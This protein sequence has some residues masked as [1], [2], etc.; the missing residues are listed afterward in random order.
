MG[1]SS[2]PQDTRG[3]GAGMAQALLLTAICSVAV[4][5]RSLDR[6]LA[7]YRDLLGVRLGTGR[8]GS[9]SCADKVGSPDARPA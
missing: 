8:I 9:R 1:A 6:S 3:N 5:V 4:Q 7:F 2:M